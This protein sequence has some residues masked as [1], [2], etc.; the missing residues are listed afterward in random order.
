MRKH[1]PIDGVVGV[2][3]QATQYYGI[4]HVLVCTRV[5]LVYAVMVCVPFMRAAVTYIFMIQTLMKTHKYHQKM[6]I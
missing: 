6:R 5:V 4:G 3:V 1:I 2:R